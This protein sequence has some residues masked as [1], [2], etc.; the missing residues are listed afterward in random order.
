VDVGNKKNDLI[1]AIYQRTLDEATLKRAEAKSESVPWTLIA[2]LKK[3]VQSDNNAIN[4]ALSTLKTWG[5]SAEDIQAVL[6]EAE[7]VKE[8]RGKHDKSKDAVWPRIEIKAPLDGIIVEKSVSVGDVIADNTTN[9]FQVADLDVLCVTANCQEDDMP[10]LQALPDQLR[11]WTVTTV[12]SPPIEGTFDDIGYI[13]DTNDHTVKVRGHIFNRDHIL[14]AAQFASATVEL[15][16]PAD[17]VEVPMNAVNDD[18]QQSIV[19]VQTDAARQYYTMRRVEMVGRFETTAFVRS[20]PFD[21]GEQLT[22][23]EAV[24]AMLPKEPLRP[25]ERILE[26][27][28]GELKALLLDKETQPQA[29]DTAGG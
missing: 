20:R 24:L 12:G 29:K 23:D 16:P 28:V 9:L 8:N 14:R 5:I 7:K 2:N 27:G 4:R 1:D 13:V 22:A 25:G 18:G 11:R 15:A 26:S 17:V 6:D 21:K 10:K 19:F 3:N